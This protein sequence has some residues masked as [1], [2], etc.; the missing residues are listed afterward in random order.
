M[1]HILSTTPVYIEYI[2]MVPQVTINS[3]DLPVVF[4]DTSMELH[5]Q[6]YSP[7]ETPIHYSAQII[8][9]GRNN[10]RLS[11]ALPVLRPAVPAKNFLL[12]NAF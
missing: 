9:M 8:A 2:H 6:D 7:K 5:Q 11:L 3:H 10:R 1:D 12:N 4:L